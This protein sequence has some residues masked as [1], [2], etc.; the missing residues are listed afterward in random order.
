MKSVLFFIESLGGGGAEAALTRLVENIDKSKY[1]VY[2]VSETD[3]EFNTERIRQNSTYHC[4]AS[5]NITGNKIKEIKNRLIFKFSVSAPMSLVY[6]V[7][8]GGKYDIEVAFCEGYSTKLISHSPN[9]KSKKIAWVH[10]DFINHPWSVK[11]YSSAEE[12]KSCYDKFDV[13]NCI[14]Q[15]ARDAFIKKYGLAEKTNVVYNVVD[16][17]F[18]LNESMEEISLEN[19]GGLTLLAL[20]RLTEVKGF[21]RLLS[22][23]LR[24]KNEGYKFKLYIL[25]KG[26]QEEDLK[27][28][29]AENG[30]EGCA[31]LSGFQSNP[32]KFMR[33]ADMVV[34]SSYAE[35][36]STVATEALVLNTPIITTDCSGMKE[37]FGDYDCGIICD[38]SEEALYQ[39]L[40]KVFDNPE[41]LKTFSNNE[42]IRAKD[43]VLENQLRIIEEIFN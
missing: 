6:R 43:F 42:K 1:K 34:C 39:A 4:F 36:M 37:I 12:E 23:A 27:R 19:N 18:I 10:T 25:G 41:L 5:M 32:Y 13:I 38:N 40:K 30:L 17:K 35:G 3:N 22:I 16:E 9:K 33:M 26:E 8:I 29:I 7:L 24:L 20:G 11:A 15:T 31:E 21:K 2:V 28:F 14:S